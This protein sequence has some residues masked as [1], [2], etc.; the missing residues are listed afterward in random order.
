MICIT[1]IGIVSALGIGVEA[2]SSALRSLHSGIAPVRWLDTVHKEMLAGEV[3]A[4]NSELR[5]LLNMPVNQPTNRTILLGKLALREA[6]RHAGPLPQSA[7]TALLNGT[8]VGGMDRSEQLIREILAGG[9]SFPDAAL[10]DCGATTDGIAEGEGSW[11]VVTTLSTACSSAANAIVVGAGM[12]RAGKA[13]C[14]VAGG[15]EC[16]SKFHLNGFNSLMILDSGRCR[17]FADDRAGL[18]LGEGAAYVVLESETSA[19]ARGA[20][21][22]GYL[23]GWKNACDAFHLT[24]TSP[25]GDGARLAMTGAL[26]TAGLKPSDID[27]VNAHGTGTPNNDATELE[28]LQQVFGENLPPFA[29]T[30]WL[31]GHTT[32]ASG[33]I[34]AVFC[35]LALQQQ[36]LPGLSERP[37]RPLRHILCNA[38]GFGGN[39]SA[40]IFSSDASR[41]ETPVP[42]VPQQKIII[43]DAA[44][45]SLQQPFSDAWIESPKT[46]DTPYAR[47]VDPDFKPWMS[48]GEARRLGRM[49]K[50]VLATTKKVLAENHIEHPDAIITGTGLGSIEDTEQILFQMLENGET[51]VS[52]THFMQS[53]HNTLSSVIA[54]ATRTHSYNAT[55]S[56]RQLSFESAMYDACM[57][58]QNAEVRNVLLGAHDGM[59]ENYFRFLRS[60][61][62]VGQPRQWTASEVAVSFLLR[63]ADA[64]EAKGQVEIAG[65]RLFHRPSLAELKQALDVMLHDGGLRLSD[66][67]GVLTG[68]NGSADNDTYYNNVC[69]RL[70][71]GMRL[72]LYKHLFGENYTVSALGMYAAFRIL[73][74]SP[75]PAALLLFN[76]SEAGASL[77]LLKK[78]L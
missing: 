60:F 49:L 53:T 44:Q 30:K 52:P 19:N 39:D 63:G 7:R 42:C 31:T 69:P 76:N 13:D 72:I 45:I 62:Y 77:T 59:T 47:A 21:I 15:S 64:S 36:F 57:Q 18:N 10:H 11:A 75:L 67:G 23:S 43:Q 33:S 17:P 16:L 58:L 26:Q 28:A 65:H 40:L 22:L 38:F 34:E 9:A 6:L 46:Y 27:Y 48:A 20:Q 78:E 41:T 55:Y 24:A 3:P 12:I 29:S 61:G 35:L 74:R 8:T 66:I 70:F 37:S 51:M 1:G 54:I 25:D 32:S 14:V 2:N 50:R 73:Q 71:P 68:V 4:S 56:H 5:A